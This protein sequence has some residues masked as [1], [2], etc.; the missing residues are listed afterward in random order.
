MKAV[1][2]P[3]TASAAESSESTHLH[4][5]LL[6]YALVAAAIIFG[7]LALSRLPQALQ[8]AWFI[9][10]DSAGTA[11]AL[12]TGAIALAYFRSF[13]ARSLLFVSIGILGAGLFDGIHL[14][15]QL[16]L[17][18]NA[19]GS[20]AHRSEMDSSL[21]G[22]VWLGVLLLMG[23]RASARRSSKAPFGVL[24]TRSIVIR[25]LFALVL[26]TA[27]I[28]AQSRGIAV[29]GGGATLRIV[30]LGITLMF[31]LCLALFLLR[32]DWR[33]SAIRRGFTLAM[34]LVTGSHLTRVVGGPVMGDPLAFG[35]DMLRNLGY[36]VAFLTLL[37]STTGFLKQVSD[38]RLNARIEALLET[39][40]SLPSD[41]GEQCTAA[42]VAHRLHGA[43]TFDLDFASGRFQGNLA[44]ARLFGSGAGSNNIEKFDALVHPDDLPALRRALK[45]SKEQGAM[46]KQEYRIRTAEGERWL[47]GIGGVEFVDGKP[48]RLLGFVDDISRQK[49]LELERDQLHDDLEQMIAAVDQLASTATLDRNGVI[50]SANAAFCNFFG[51]PAEQL[52]GCRLGALIRAAAAESPLP[53]DLD[54]LDPDAPWFGEVRLERADG[55]VRIAQASLTPHR[56]HGGEHDTLV[57]VGFDVTERVIAQQSLQDSIA[58]HRK[59]NE[60][61]QMFAHIVSHDLQEPLRMVSS[62]M[63]LL[64]RRYAADLESDAREF[65]QFAVEGVQRMRGLLDGLLEYSR[66]NSE[67]G[68]FQPV[69]LEQLVAGAVGNLSV[70]I[71]ETGAEIEVA[72]SPELQADPTQ[73]IQLFQNLL[74]NAIKFCP[75]K[76]PRILIAG[77]RDGDT[78][79]VTVTD[80]GIGIEEAHYLRIFQIFQRL[81]G[82]GE[83][84]GSGVGLAVC[85]RIMERHRGRIDVTSQPGEGTVFS[86][87]FPAI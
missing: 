55:S 68:D 59:S 24:A 18:Q 50:Q 4:P 13:N 70:L 44:T 30:E 39:Q 87:E 34:L 8:P 14:M 37:A 62:F 71:G 75:G 77:R 73:M 11:L 32:G 27:L 60:D 41:C 51:S 48:A 10:V 84:A 6:V 61:L 20:S 79:V 12:L 22:Q 78:A 85:K 29:Q 65:I 82:R 56:V 63:A 67:G 38:S 3:G 19:L 47:E 83:Y 72:G 35:A 80:N 49:S 86:L 64:E 9:A 25:S 1:L 69:A 36:F 58:A 31:V 21:L 2:V 16:E 28:I 33:G 46:F 57:Y 26:L 76:T 5:R 74:A 43:G 45:L 52:T 23:W 40:P 54:A 53:D 42:P 66:V 15:L 81:H 17:G 7:M